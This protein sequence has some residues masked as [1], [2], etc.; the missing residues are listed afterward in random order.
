MLFNEEKYH[1]PKC[2]YRYSHE[3]QSK[4]SY[5]EV[6]PGF[7]KFFDEIASEH[8]DKRCHESSRNYRD[9]AIHYA[10]PM[11]RNNVCHPRCW[12]GEREG[13][14]DN[15]SF[16]EVFMDKMITFDFINL[17]R[18]SLFPLD[19]RKSNKKED[20]SSRDA[21]IFRFEA[22][23]GEEVLSENKGRKHCYEEY[24][25]EAHPIF[26]ILFL[27]RIRVKFRVEG[28]GCQWLKEG[29]ER[30]KHCSDESDIEWVEHKR[31]IV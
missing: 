21:K 9:N 15:K 24:Q 13:K 27:V 30:K 25:P 10:I 5:N 29:N 2:L 4:N 31:S 19:H 12:E 6:C 7:S 14:G 11:H 28:E 17:R 23:K 8:D 1:F 22:K 18:I 3:K 26:S 20:N 16:I